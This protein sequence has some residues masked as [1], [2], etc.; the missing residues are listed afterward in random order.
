MV[1][2]VKEPIEISSS[3]GV[4]DALQAFLRYLVVIVGFF[5]AL[6]SLLGKQDAVG[7]V[8]YAQT[9]LGGLVSAVFGLVALGT[10]AYGIYKSFK[11]GAQLVDVEPHTPNAVLRLKK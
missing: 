10:A 4:T 2:E 7:A 8:T 3:Q 11:R 6:G 9:N 1:G 5:S